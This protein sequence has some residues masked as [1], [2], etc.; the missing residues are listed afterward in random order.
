MT[1]R[2]SRVPLWDAAFEI[3][4][5][6]GPGGEKLRLDEA[7]GTLAAEALRRMSSVEDDCYVGGGDKE[8]RDRFHAEASAYEGD[9]GNGYVESFLDGD[10]P[11]G[12]D[13]IGG[14]PAV[15][16]DPPVAGEEGE[17]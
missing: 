14:N 5:E 13:G 15:E 7:V 8:E 4:R 2:Q 17:S 1:K 6:R 11:E 16:A 3:D 9:D 10:A 12:I